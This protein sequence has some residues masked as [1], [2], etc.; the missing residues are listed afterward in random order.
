[1]NAEILLVD[2]E[3]AFM[4][5]EVLSVLN[6]FSFA[7]E[8]RG[9]AAVARFAQGGID[10]VLMDIRLPG[11]INGLMATRLIRRMNPTVPII[12]MSG[13]ED[14]DT[15]PQAAAAGAND[16]MVKPVNY[17]R[18]FN[19]INELLACVA[20]FPAEEHQRRLKAHKQRRLNTLRERAAKMGYET[21]GSV[22]MEIEDLEAELK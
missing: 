21:P 13:Y 11:A 2:D 5:E 12:L 8:T 9:D 6:G 20:N 22:T 14:S 3:I 15:W 19:R 18:L 1:V 4:V 7:I 16:F 17:H 10:L